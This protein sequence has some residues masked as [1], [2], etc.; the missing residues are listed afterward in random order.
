MLPQQKL[1]EVCH[2]PLADNFYFCPNCGKQLISRGFFAIEKY[3]I[4]P[5]KTCPRCG[6]SI[7][8][9]GEYIESKEVSDKDLY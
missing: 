1:C 9:V 5:E 4:T 2:F 8:I 6:E 3:E 7:P